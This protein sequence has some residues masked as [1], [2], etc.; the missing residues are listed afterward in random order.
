VSKF[1][2][3][4]L[5]FVSTATTA[6]IGAFVQTGSAHCHKVMADDAPAKVSF[7]SDLAFVKGSP[8]AKTVFEGAHARF[9][10]CCPALAT[11]KPALL[12]SALPDWGLNGHGP[13]EPL[14]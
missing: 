13:V 4:W 8:H 2:F 11:P 3:C 9:N 7:K 6:L 1:G 12:L 14:G 10:A 5:A